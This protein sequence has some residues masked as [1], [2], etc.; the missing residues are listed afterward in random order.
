LIEP[1]FCCSNAH[2]PTS[3]EEHALRLTE[4]T[5]FDEDQ[6]ISRHTGGGA[7]NRGGGGFG[8]GGYTSDMLSASTAPPVVFAP[9]WSIPC[10][11]S[12]DD[13]VD[14]DED[15]EDDQDGEGSGFGVNDADDVDE[16]SEAMS[17]GSQ[18]EVGECG[19]VQEEEEEGTSVDKLR[20]CSSSSPQRP[21][22]C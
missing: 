10:G 15:D 22:H 8:G 2:S 21:L 11:E 4:T 18:S 14:G 9:E 5:P 12:T 3:A 13:D 7:G 17:G 20:E 6:G 19:M 1:R 16:A